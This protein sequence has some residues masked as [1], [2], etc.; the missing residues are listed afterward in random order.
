MCTKV[1]FVMIQQIT[2]SQ[3]GDA[4]DLATGRN[5]CDVITYYSRFK[6]IATYLKKL[7]SMLVTFP[8]HS[9]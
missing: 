8:V 3:V 2:G 6:V 7:K 1:R 4:D 5:Q 9:C